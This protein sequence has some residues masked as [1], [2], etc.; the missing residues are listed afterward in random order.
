M[1]ERE[2]QKLAVKILR[3]AGFKV[4]VTSNRRPTANTEGLPDVFA[5]FRGK[6]YALECKSDTGKPTPKQQELIDLGA[7]ILIDSVDSIHAF[8]KECF[9]LP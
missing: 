7:S 1:T 9:Q 2:I 8:V 3:S 5:W 6:W 4:Y